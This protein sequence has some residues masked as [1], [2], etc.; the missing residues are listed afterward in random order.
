MDVKDVIFETIQERDMSWDDAAAWYP[1]LYAAATT[2][3]GGA[4]TYTKHVGKSC[5]STQPDALRCFVGTWHECKQKCSELDRDKRGSCTAFSHVGPGDG[6]SG[7]CVVHSGTVSVVSMDSI[8]RSSP[9][10]PLVACA[11][12]F[13]SA[14]VCMFM[15]A[16]YIHF[17]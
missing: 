14:Y 16:Q 3:H 8:T 1:T 5:V 11:G 17:F 7:K 4:V 6:R 12:S 15:P 2:P 9:P 13:H 10:Q